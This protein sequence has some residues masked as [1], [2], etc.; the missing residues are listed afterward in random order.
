MKDVITTF[1]N[2]ALTKVCAFNQSKYLVGAMLAG[3]L[4][5]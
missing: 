2:T 4:L 3:F 5:A 1:S